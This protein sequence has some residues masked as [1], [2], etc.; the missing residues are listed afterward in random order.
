[1][2]CGYVWKYSWSLRIFAKHGHS[3]HLLARRQGLLRQHSTLSLPIMSLLHIIPRWRTT[4]CGNAKNALS[5]CGCGGPASAHNDNLQTMNIARRVIVVPLRR[6]FALVESCR[7]SAAATPPAESSATDKKTSKPRHTV[8][9]PASTV[10]KAIDELRTASWAKFDET[11][12]V[13]I[14]TGLDP[15]KPNQSVKGVAKLPS[16]TGKKVRIAVVAGPADAKAALAEGVEV[17]GLDEVIALFHSGDVNFNTVIAT[18]D[19]MPALSKLGKV[20]IF[21]SHE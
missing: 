20:R 14:N 7:F 11:L 16:G 8:S 2:Y 13:S 21:Y 17:A 4:R 3:H 10:F 1:M 12:E 15:R 9:L 5:I 6:P 19:V 18:P